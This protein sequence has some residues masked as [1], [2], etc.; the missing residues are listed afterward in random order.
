MRE[1]DIVRRQLEPAARE[2]Q[3]L[4][5]VAWQRSRAH[6]VYVPQATAPLPKLEAD[7][8]LLHAPQRGV[9]EQGVQLVLAQHL[10][11]VTVFASLH[12][13]GEPPDRAPAW[14]SEGSP[15]VAKEQ[16]L[17][18]AEALVVCPRVEVDDSCA[19]PQRAPPPREHGDGALPGGEERDVVDEQAVGE[20]GEMICD[21]HHVICTRV[22][23]GANKCIST[24]IALMNLSSNLIWFLRPTWVRLGEKVSEYWANP[25]VE[26]YKHTGH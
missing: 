24:R 17:D 5:G 19:E 1:G 11:A 16:L 25:V 13:Q 10:L 26:M 7:V 22:V 2:V 9:G 23:G 21:S 4:E 20:V 15:G 6:L 14:R 8:Q 3:H 18:L 12:E